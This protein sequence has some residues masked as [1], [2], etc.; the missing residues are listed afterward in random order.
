MQQGTGFAYP[1][2]ATIAPVAVVQPAYYGMAFVADFIGSDINN[3]LRVYDV[4][5]CK[6]L[7]IA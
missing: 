5:L 1:P 4:Y 7:L 2:R 3:E 6:F